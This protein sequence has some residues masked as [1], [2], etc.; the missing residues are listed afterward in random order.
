ML[1][2]KKFMS[3]GSFNIGQKKFTIFIF[4]L[5][6]KFSQK[7]Y[8]SIYIYIVFLLLKLHTHKKK[9]KINLY[10][11]KEEASAFLI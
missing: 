10:N 7:I 8:K 5:C 11:N 2:V 4:R 3:S 9:D 1:N 6:A